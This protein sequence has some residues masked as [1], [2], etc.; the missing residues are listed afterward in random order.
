MDVHVGLHS[1]ML[2]PRRQRPNWEPGLVVGRLY[3]DGC[4]ASS[5]TGTL[6]SAE[7][8]ETRLVPVHDPTSQY[9]KT[10]GTT[11]V[12]YNRGGGGIIRRGV[13]ALEPAS[14]S[15]GYDPKLPRSY[16]PLTEDWDVPLV[17]WALV[18]DDEEEEEDENLNNEDE[19]LAS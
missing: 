19:E 18:S 1:E 2:T 13:A 14:S 16:L 3:L 8:Q 5:G 9:N 11:S 4:L 17:E 15:S 12:G 10:S 7:S 6:S